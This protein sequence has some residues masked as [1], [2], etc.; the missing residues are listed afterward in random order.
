MVGTAETTKKWIQSQRLDTIAAGI[1][2]DF[3]V[4][5]KPG[6]R[7]SELGQSC[8]HGIPIVLSRRLGRAIT[9]DLSCHRADPKFC[10][11]WS[12]HDSHQVCHL[13]TL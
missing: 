13:L 10:E 9:D 7:G 8:Y 11:S 2:V 3:I 12:Q 6:C 4:L 1:R 5:S